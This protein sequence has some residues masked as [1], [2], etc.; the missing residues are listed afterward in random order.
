M[1]R[2][3][4]FYRL[5]TLLLTTPAYLAVAQQ[6]PPAAASPDWAKLVENA[7]G[8][9]QPV[10]AAQLAAARGR[11]QQA[12]SRLEQALGP[13]SQ[14]ATTWKEFLHWDL[15]QPHLQAPADQLDREA[16]ANLARIE[17]RFRAN[18]PGLELPVFRE[19]AEALQ[20]YRPTLTWAMTADARDAK[21]VY[22]F[23]LRNLERQLTR[24]AQQPTE[25][26]HWQIAQY[27]EILAQL[28][29][30]PELVAALEQAYRHPNL[31]VRAS[32]RLVE[33]AGQ[34]PVFETQPVED[35]ILGTSISGCAT[36]TGTVQFRLC[37]NND[38]ISLC[39]V[40][41]ACADSQTIG[42]NGPVK[43]GATGRTCFTG[44]KQIWLSDDQ[45]TT[46]PAVVSATTNT[47]IHSIQKT[48]G[49][50]GHKLVE[51]IA[52][53]R[54]GESKHKSEYVA[55][56]HAEERVAR[57]LNTQVA[58]AIAEGRGRYEQRV[59]APLTRRDLMP[60]YFRAWSSDAWLGVETL[61]GAEGQLSAYGPPPAY[62]SQSDVS[63]RL[64]ESSVGNYLPFALGGVTIEQ[65]EFD[66]PPQIRGEAPRWLKKLARGPLD[67]DDDPSLLPRRSASKEPMTPEQ[68]AAQAENFRPWSI[69][70]NEQAPVSVSFDDG[71][72][73]IRI[74]ASR[75]ASEDR[76]YENWDFVVKY[77]VQQS[78]EKIVLRRVGK[79]EIF[80]SGFDPRW[81][82]K[83]P[84]AKASFR[85]TLA[86]NMNARAE[87]GEG[88]PPEI[89]I[90]AVKLPNL[91][92]LVLTELSS[93]DGWLSVAWRLP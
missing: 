90:P 40:L 63:F 75:L 93:D 44:T 26:T 10:T 50:L 91:G 7:R 37:P 74:R 23:L 76:E 4:A 52:W 80:P 9:H 25:E 16:L 54:A 2:N 65:T 72:L 92:K 66:Q 86:K 60:D 11:L 28:D 14:L 18:E 17:K 15:L 58:E 69:T 68:R 19:T 82:E 8:D 89:E 71:Q 79:I 59:Q 81:D 49:R 34:R 47:N 61:V 20:H 88:F 3:H 35:C 77:E 55:A 31:Y 30:S 24:H 83:M 27:Y 13:G 39:A 78:G 70:F 41:S 56:R 21:A 42:Y 43:I 1:L 73:S 46:T 45:F 64:H 5:L 57:N 38:Q 53:K 6:T 84:A 62:A 48:G 51:R 32:A 36:T 12:A 85:Q 33:R 87:R 22:D 67:T 29:D